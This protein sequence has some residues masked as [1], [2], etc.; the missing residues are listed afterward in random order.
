MEFPE[1][2]PSRDLLERLCNLRTLRWLELR[3]RSLPAKDLAVVGN[4]ERLE[5]LVVMDADCN[6]EWLGELGRLKRL[7]IVHLYRVNVTMAGLEALC[8]VRPLTA[9]TIGDVPA[10]PFERVPTWTSL[11]NLETLN[12]RNS[13]V[14]LEGARTLAEMPA[15]RHLRMRNVDLPETGLKIL[16]EQGIRV[17]IEDEG[18]PPP[19]D[20]GKEVDASFLL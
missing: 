12:L 6:D 4:C 10:L 14:S 13:R 7:G 16:L 15:L 20:R 19:R 8:Q 5:A 1:S 9:L 17:Q 3:S 11:S 2:R 18:N